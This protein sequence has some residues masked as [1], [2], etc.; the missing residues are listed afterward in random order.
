MNAYFEK[1]KRI[2]QHLAPFPLLAEVGA[3]IT[4]DN[5]DVYINSSN[6]MYIYPIE[7]R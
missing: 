7:T 4:T 1:F 6:Y 5:T 2:I 3:F